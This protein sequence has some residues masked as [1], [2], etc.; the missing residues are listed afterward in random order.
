[1]DKILQNTAHI[2]KM[3]EDFTP[4]IKE[5]V[6]RLS[7]LGWYID[8]ETQ[9]LVDIDNLINAPDNEIDKIMIANLEKN[10]ESIKS[11]VFL[12]FPNRY[13]PLRAAFQSHESGEYFSSIP[14]FLPQI[15]GICMDKTQ[16]NIFV[17][18]KGSSR[19]GT[20]EFVESIKDDELMSAMLQAIDSDHPLTFNKSTRPKEF[21]GLNRHAVLH[22]ES[23]DYGTKINSLK[24]ISF[25][26]YF[27]SIFAMDKK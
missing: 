12:A 20:A 21:V 4:R 2:L 24:L 1:M 27:E 13:E 25:F 3:V 7:G 6:K 22:G 26:S 15:D 16:K 19:I 9:D 23:L 18:K 5:A 17:R 14:T 11:R 8:F 10:M